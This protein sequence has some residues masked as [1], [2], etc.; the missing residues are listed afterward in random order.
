M[1]VFLIFYLFF[2]SLV[3]HSPSH[4]LSPPLRHCFGSFLSPLYL[5]ALVLPSPLSASIK[6]PH[7]VNSSVIVPPMDS[8]SLC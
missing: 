4:S 1:N 6:T 2:Y 5:I 3:S 8:L 7:T